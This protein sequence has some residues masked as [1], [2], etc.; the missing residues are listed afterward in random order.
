MSMTGMPESGPTRVGVAIGDQTA[1]MWA[2]LGVIAALYDRRATGKGRRVETSLLAGLVG[3]LSVQ[4][5]RYLSLGEVPIP[6]GNSHPVISPYG[7]FRTGDGPLNIA[8]AT[9]A[10][11]TRLCGILNLQGLVDDPRFANNT[12]RV[13]HREELKRLLEERLSGHPRQYWMTR[14]AQAGIPC[15]PINNLAE[16]FADEQVNH[17]SMVEKIEHP[18]LGPLQLVSSPIKLNGGDERVVRRHPPLLGEHT[19][20][21]LR[22]FGYSEATLSE[23]TRTEAVSQH[24]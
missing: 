17:C 22:E 10:M 14:F 1:G 19:F 2:A 13:E 8:P 3:L 4:G 7:V 20:E 24:A 15:G 18:T 9:G 6:T 11:W 21:L 16:V 5:Q 23:L 12:T